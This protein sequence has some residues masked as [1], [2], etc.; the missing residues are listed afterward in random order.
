[1]GCDLRHCSVPHY[2]SDT[3]LIGLS[4]SAVFDYLENLRHANPYI[5]VI[6]FYFSFSDREKQS[7][8]NMIRSL[9]VQLCGRRSDTPKPLLDL[10]RFR[11]VNHQPDPKNL[12]TTLRACVQ[13]FQNVYL[14]IDA[15]DECPVAGDE[16]E[17]LKC[18][19]R[20]CQIKVAQPTRTLYKP[21]R[22]GY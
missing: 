16:R 1:M 11:D 5:A 22:A 3:E 20:C 8:E 7:T 15:L 4:S 13:D 12:E 21:T 2:P 9:I 14:I 19:R 17:A 10:R 6:Y 18:P